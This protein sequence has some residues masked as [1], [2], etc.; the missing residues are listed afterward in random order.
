[1]A[2]YISKYTGKQ[3][4]GAIK[5]FE[6][7]GL[8]DVIG[9]V[10]RD[11]QGNFSTKTISWS[12]IDNNS[13]PTTL[14]GYGITDAVPA[15][16]IETVTTD[17]NDK[18]STSKAMKTYVDTHGG[19]IDT[20]SVNGTQQSIVNKNVDISVPIN[21]SDLNNDDDF[22]TG[23]Q[24]ETAIT[25]KMGAANG[26]AEL[27]SNK[28]V[29]SNQLPSYVDDVLEFANRSAFPVGGEAGKIYV[30]LDTNLTYRW[31]GSEYVEISQS[32]ALGETNSTAYRGDRGAAAY[33][34]AVI[35]KGSQ[36]T[37]GLYKFATN[38]EGHVITATAVQNGADIKTIN[39]QNVLGSGN[40]VIHPGMENLVDGSATG[41]VRGINTTVE[42]SSYTM[43]INAFA[44]GKNTKAIGDGSHAEGENTVANGSNSHA[45]GYGSRT[46]FL[47]SH[48]EGYQTVAA[49]GYSHAEGH[50]TVA[51]ASY[52]HAEGFSTNAEQV[53]S[54]A[55][56]GMT[57]A[58]GIA[59]H[60][61][62]SGTIA[63]KDAQ[64]AIGKYN[65]EDTETVEINQK[66]FIIGNGTNDSN[67]SNALTV[68]WSGNVNIA[69]GASYKINGV[70][71][72]ASDVGAQPTLIS[73]TN[74][75]TINGDSLLGSGN[76][77]IGG[78]VDDVTVDGIS[79]VSNKI[80][81]ISLNGKQDIL[82]SGTNIKTIN[83]ESVLGSG[84]I[85]IGGGGVSVQSNW[86]ETDTSSAAY[87][88]NKPNLST[89]ATSGNYNDLTNKP[90]LSTVA[91]SGAYNDLSGKP[92]LSA[93]ATTGSYNDLTD[94]PT[95]PPQLT[96]GTGIT[97]DSNNVISVN[98][99]NAETQSF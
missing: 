38:S 52:A 78:N 27:D 53:G 46:G 66:A 34:H 93:V 40:L 92:S 61:Q 2:S 54:H 19:K 64:T 72:S 83:G 35:N 65:I 25:S 84:N 56:G 23:A 63:A 20:I 67:R 58:S 1:M 18:I 48:A 55:E 43:G 12:D 31:S 4:D 42:G 50:S 6:G 37:N 89:V 70:A 32:L 14:S 98:L 81:A 57:V 15:S 77:T 90:T 94:K 69:S 28:K 21:T 87:I 96:A 88:L 85:E 60:A 16:M 22:R 36:F 79:V 8:S 29:P 76:L 10:Q 80:A 97:I 49:G 73:G 9:I 3:I 33:T 91:T 11:S 17:S 30:A 99:V 44:E 86:T 26:I 75:K 62:N 47:T 68:D 45:E 24:V 59:A 39:G 5:L 74:I 82:V 7:K 95:I 13:K 51:N 71:L 41:S